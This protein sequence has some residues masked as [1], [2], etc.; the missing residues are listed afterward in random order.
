MD[1]MLL[2]GNDKEIIQELKTQLSSKFY[3][4][5]VGLA[6]FILDMEIRG[7]QEDRKLWLN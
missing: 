5:Y 1:D 7:D 4:R 6:N 2:N 3:M